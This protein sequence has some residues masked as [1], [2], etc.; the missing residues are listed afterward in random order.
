[1]TDPR[2]TDPQP[3]DPQG[4]D[5]QAI[6]LQDARIRS[7]RFDEQ[8][9]CV[10]IELDLRESRATGRQ[11]RAVL[12][13]EGV[14][15]SPHIAETLKLANHARAGNVLHWAPSWKAGN[16]FIYL[17]DGVISIWAQRLSV[18]LDEPRKE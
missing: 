6:E 18:K 4:I 12:V 11:K 15:P 14:R 17:M 3:T 5:P 8:S 16:T 2:P 1:M 13:F 7:G 9:G 10:S